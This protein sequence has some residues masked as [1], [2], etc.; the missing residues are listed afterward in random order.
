[1][2]SN[3]LFRGRFVGYLCGFLFLAI[4][5]TELSLRFVLGLGNPVLITADSAT[6]YL[7]APNQKIYRFFCHTRTN[8][9]GMRSDNFLPQPAPGTERILF[10]GDSVT[11]G[12]SHVDQAKIFTEE[13]HHLL[14]G[15]VQH[16]VE[17]LNASAGGWAIDNELGYLTSRGSFHAS[18]IVL[19]LN[20][21]DLLQS[22][23]DFNSAGEDT[24]NQRPLL[25]WIELWQR[26]LRPKFFHRGPK[27]D[28]GDSV[29][30]AQDQML[31]LNF[32]KIQAAENFAQQN[33]AVL[34]VLY[35]PFRKDIP[36]PNQQLKGKFFPW[37]ASH[38]IAVIDTTEALGAYPIRQVTR[39]GDHL[40]VFGNQI[41][42]EQ[43]LAAWPSLP[44]IP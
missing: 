39:D 10:L 9:Y 22:R 41:V 29:N 21:G 43:A 38:H 5:I 42:A 3:R 31:N 37:L 6:S 26:F 4:L 30:L 20:D 24:P 32:A 17:V 27:I 19:V 25:A 11:Y 13:L 18:R 33:H 1:M 35:I 14:P 34:S 15:K 2:P 23:A 28:A 44:T 16:P 40:T 12:T 8:P 7:L 36:E